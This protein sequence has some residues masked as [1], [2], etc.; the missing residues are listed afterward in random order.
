MLFIAPLASIAVSAGNSSAKVDSG[1]Q[2]LLID[3]DTLARVYNQGLN[4][5]FEKAFRNVEVV[6][7]PDLARYNA[8]L[9]DASLEESIHFFGKGKAEYYFKHPKPGVLD[10]LGIRVD[11]ILYLTSLTVSIKDVPAAEFQSGGGGGSWSSGVSF[12]GSGPPNVTQA[13]HP[14]GGS[15][16]EKLAPKLTAFAKYILWDYRK[17]AAV[18][19]GQFQME[20]GVDADDIRGQWEKISRT[21]KDKITSHVSMLD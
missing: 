17:S 9:T 5:R 18:A 19:Y 11:L 20:S 3:K 13:F 1:K 21:V 16:E 7:G 12:N 10:S 4:A 14:G 8:A 2:A 6:P 15:I